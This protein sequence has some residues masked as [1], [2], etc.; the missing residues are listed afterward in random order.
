MAR[1]ILKHLIN[2]KDFIH[3]IKFL[4]YGMSRRNF[5]ITQN[6]NSFKRCRN[7]RVAART[8]TDAATAQLTARFNK[9]VN[10]LE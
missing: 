7:T 10:S 5:I 4:A 1:N 3:I 6:N 8:G 9:D 2:A